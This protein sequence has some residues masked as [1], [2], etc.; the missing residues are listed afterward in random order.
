MIIHL[1]EGPAQ[2]SVWKGWAKVPRIGCTSSMPYIAFKNKRRGGFSW[3][4]SILNLSPAW[5]GG[6]WLSSLRE[7]NQRNLGRPQRR[8]R[9][10]R[11][12]HL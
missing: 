6:F 4:Q 11:C 10:E 9:G 12:G 7:T 1:R 2:A 3:S 8:H 5:T